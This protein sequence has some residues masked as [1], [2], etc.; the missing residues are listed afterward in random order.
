MFFEPVLNGIE[1]LLE[2]RRQMRQ[3][4]VQLRNITVGKPYDQSEHRQTS[5]KI[6][7]GPERSRTGTPR[8]TRVTGMPAHRFKRPSDKFPNDDH[9]DDADPQW[10]AR[11]ERDPK[12]RSSFDQ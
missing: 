3:R 8:P 6:P 9:E 5:D 2:K 4:L 10:N 1:Q 7:E 12:N 11:G